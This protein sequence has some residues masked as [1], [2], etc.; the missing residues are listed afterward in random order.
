MLNVY[1]GCQ[2]GDASNFF[3]ASVYLPVSLFLESIILKCQIQTALRVAL[4][5]QV[6]A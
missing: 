6:A 5:A 4:A 3:I 2:R 1:R